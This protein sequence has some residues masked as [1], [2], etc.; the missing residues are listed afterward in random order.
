MIDHVLHKKPMTTIADTAAQV[1]PAFAQRA[2]SDP[3]HSVWVS[4]SAGSGKTTVLTNRVMRLLL[5]G[6][7]PQKI[8]CLTFTRAAAAEM[9]NRVTERLSFWATCS[10]D[11]LSESLGLLQGQAPKPRQMTLARR[12]FA[13]VL[14]CPGGMRI[15]TIHAFCQEI[16]GRFPIEA[17]LPTHFSVIDEGD[18]QDLMDAAQRELLRE[19]ED[20]PDPILSAAFKQITYDLGERG[21]SPAVKNILRERARIDEAILRAG[22]LDSLIARMRRALGLASD[23]NEPHIIREVVHSSLLPEKDLR[24]AAA[25]MRE[26]K[27]TVRERGEEIT[28]W[29]LLPVE[30]RCK[31]FQSYWRCF[32]TA[33]EEPF[34]KFGDKDL[35]LKYPDLEGLISRETHRLQSVLERLES[36]RFA[37]TTEA[38]LRVGRALSAR[39]AERKG[40]QAALD[41]DDLIIYTH[42]LLYRPGIAPWVLY[43]LDG[44]LD[45]IMVDE[46]QDTS[47]AQWSI[48][49]ALADEFF[50]GASA[51]DNQQ[52]TLFVVGDEKQSIFSFQNADPEAFAEMRNYFAQRL[53]EIGLD[54]RSIGLHTSFRSAP[55][56]LKAV[57]RVFASD[58]A[59][60]GVASEVI[61]HRAARP[62]LGDNEKIG[63]IEVWSLLTASK[64]EAAGDGTWTLPSG[65]EDEIDPQSDCAAMIADTIS[66]WLI[67]KDIHKGTQEL[68]RPGDIMILLR[69]RGRFAD[70]MVR[71]L[72]QRNI[73]VTGVDKMKLAEQLSVMDLL[74]LIQFALLPEDDLN[75]A[76]VLRGPF[77]NCSE[78]QLMKLAIGREGSLWRSLISEAEKSE[79][80]SLFTNYL[81]RWLKEADFITPF[82]M[83]SHIL[84]EPCPGNDISGRK[85]LWMRL[86]PDALDPIEELLNAAQNFCMRHAPSLQVFLHRILAS[87]T[88]IKRELDH[89]G[90]QVRIM[91]VHGSKGLEAPIVFLPDTTSLPRSQDVPKL[92]WDKE[93]APF[94]LVRKPKKGLAL[95]LWR[96]ARQKQL[97]E[98]RRLLYVALTRA[99]S[100]LYICGWEQSRQESSEESSWYELIEKALKPWHESSAVTPQNGPQ[101][102]ICFEDPVTQK[103]QTEKILSERKL[104]VSALPSW[105]WQAAVSE[106][107]L[108]EVLSPSR[109]EAP[110]TATPD[111]A[112]ARGRIIHRLLQS[113]PDLEASQRET[114]AKG[115]LS[116]SRHRLTPQEQAEI[117]SEVMNLILNPE[118]AP[119]FQPGS[120]AEVPLTGSVGGHVIAGQIDR[121]C[122][123]GADVWVVDYKTSRPPPQDAAETP[124]AYRL[125]MAAYRAALQD[126]YPGKTIRCFLLWTYKPVLMELPPEILV[127][128]AE[129]IAS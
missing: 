51:H 81:M 97:E 80:F 120:R 9:T 126:I 90:N 54:L 124:L 61:H 68:I 78:E 8:L 109:I 4:A 114:A 88:I 73:P 75:L 79:S 105:A 21:F 83:L 72:K 26:G 22:S 30:E 2:A 102:L 24:Q 17:G 27:K 128:S 70:L 3:A 50:V 29:L 55:G 18:A 74:A 96:E 106:P 6:V 59:R 49:K 42:A 108:L 11:E 32:L 47:R 46:A 39:I 103:T 107:S 13:Q 67:N 69:N 77:L 98:Y 115:F 111:S 65:Y 116:N 99:A 56:I 87:E 10:D 129:L 57:D 40:A 25:W 100:H 36:V 94:Y 122:V 121:L 43:K 66:N 33:E 91:T 38:I 44:G 92:L 101:P 14:S 84:N 41:Y 34:A 20:K 45:H 95:W 1:E 12:L 85:A 16:L 62:R 5:E 15:R 53:N 113:L 52:R 35:L 104:P 89:G 31:S 23:E 63:R 7:K 112:F 123:N 58:A 119:L 76:T 93:N 110:P 117:Q 64:K 60:S 118:F 28:R 71:A 86:G 19:L 127:K 48:I 37:A 82:A 125:Q